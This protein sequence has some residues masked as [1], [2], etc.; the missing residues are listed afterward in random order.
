MNKKGFTLI[1]LLIVVAII[2][3]LAA[4]AIPGYLGAQAKSKRSAIKENA[5]NFAKEAQNWLNSKYAT[6]EADHWVDINGNGLMTDAED[7]ATTYATPSALIAYAVAN[8]S[9]Y[10]QIKNPYDGTDNMFHT[11]DFTT[12]SSVNVGDAAGTAGEVQIGASDTEHAVVVCG[13]AEDKDHNSY[14]VYRQ[15]VTNE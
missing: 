14:C 13:F 12:L 11:G 15:V 3:I 8:H 9:N 1:E 7:D 10:S 2:G 6:D 4:I 5:A